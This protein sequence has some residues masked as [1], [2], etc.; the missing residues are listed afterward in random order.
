MGVI[1]FLSCLINTSCTISNKEPEM[2]L[3][4]LVQ[5]LDAANP[6][7]VESVGHILE[8]SLVAS[9]SWGPNTS[10]T[11]YQLSYGEGLIIEEVEFRLKAPANE[12][13]RLILSLSDDA[14][15][16][17]R[18][19][20]KKSY[21][22]IRP[23]PFGPPRGTSLNEKEYFWTARQWGNIAFGFKTRRPACLSSI[24]FIPKKWE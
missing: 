22:N 18:E 2:K 3:E 8:V 11:A 9:R 21:P 1:L 13:I 12:T 17:S 20:I 15:C 14:N 23:S 19:R 7:T 6:W 24:T 10:Y 16:F 4:E 5:R